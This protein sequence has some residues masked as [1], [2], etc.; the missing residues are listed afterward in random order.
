LSLHGADRA[1]RFPEIDNADLVVTTYALLSRDADHLLPVQW[2]MAVLDEAQAIKNAAAKTT[3]LVCRL[4]AR[5]RLCLTGTPMENHLGE[6]WSQFAFLMPG[7]LGDAKRFAR[8]FRTP[9]EKKQDGERRGVLSGRLKPF[10][11][12]RT[13]SLVAADLPPKTEI[14]RPLELAGPQRDL[15]ETVRVAMHEKVRRE[16]AEKGLAR[17]HIVVLDA[18]LKLRQVCCDPRLVKL[19]AARQVSASAK[20]E[21]LMEML[22]PLIEEGRQILLFSQ[23]TSMLDLIKPA[24]A[25]AGIDF[26]E[27]RGD[28]KD[29]AGP[30]AQFQKGEVPLFLI[31]LKAGGTGLNLTAADTVIHYDPWWNP[32]VEDQATDRAHRIGQDKPVFVYKLVAQGTVEER[33]LELQQRKKAL[34]AGIYDAAGGTGAGLEAGDIERLFEPLG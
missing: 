33:M 14:L 31:S 13:K 32:A 30:V 28:T 20:L 15:Y 3:Q 11:L 2:H 10:L 7:L 18:L 17:S 23:F 19:T 26:V 16:V 9:I 21:H 34:A 25:E 24:V 4:D 6:L 12:R 1:D 29:R 8:V 22:P 5:H 27:L